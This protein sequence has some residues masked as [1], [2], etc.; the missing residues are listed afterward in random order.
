MNLDLGDTRLIIDECKRYGCLRNQTAYILA[1]AYWETA[2]KMKPVVEAFWK[3]EAWRKANLRYY[4]WHG[5][6]YVQLTWERNYEKAQAETGYPVHDDPSKALDSDAAAA[7]L[8]RGSMEGW[9]TG[10][11]IG[12]YIALNK[13]DFY[14]ARRVIN[15]K[16]KASEIAKLAKEYDDDL[17]A[18]G[19]GVS[20]PTPIPVPNAKPK[21]LK[22]MTFSKEQGIGWIG[23]ILAVITAVK[24]SGV[25]EWLKT[26]PSE[27]LIGGMA[28][29]F[30]LVLANRYYARWTG[31]R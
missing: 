11:K 8:V 30:V 31:E 16:D 26:V 25:V 21:I 13:S 23:T 18:E 29:A 20:D 10:K 12:D 15:G 4:P 27:Y 14:N 19:Y 17:A 1:T 22:E 28:L 24:E 2:R 9:F 6:G 3:S 5:R 7:I